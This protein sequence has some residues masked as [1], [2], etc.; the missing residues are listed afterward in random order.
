MGGKAIE[1]RFRAHILNEERPEHRTPIQGFT[2]R[3]TFFHDIFRY[4]GEAMN[5]I[6]GLELSAKFIARLQARHVTAELLGYHVEKHLEEIYIVKERFVA[7][8]RH[9][10]K[11]F[12]RSDLREG[13]AAMTSLERQTEDG[14]QGVV[15][16]RG[17]HVH[18]RRFAD[19]DID[20]IRTLDLL[21]VS[22]GMKE[23][24]P[25]RRAHVL[26]ALT[27]WKKTTKSNVEEAKKALDHMI[28]MVEPAILEKLAPPE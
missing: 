2:K 20:R 8:I 22:G 16:A 24:A 17:A 5:A 9:L 27:K 3:E 12:K 7:F 4:F 21:M 26:T 25:L 18:E 10:R 28:D 11:L 19:E 15:R 1:E 13:V 6:S 23:L 14:F